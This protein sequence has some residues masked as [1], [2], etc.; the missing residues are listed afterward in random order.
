M[1]PYF[2]K[3]SIN[4]DQTKKKK[5]A[6]SQL[7][8]TTKYRLRKRFFYLKSTSLYALIMRMNLHWKNRFENVVPW[9]QDRNDKD[10]II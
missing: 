5:R 6:L 3:V 8:L 7:R 2:G 10:A 1:R 9:Q 4:E